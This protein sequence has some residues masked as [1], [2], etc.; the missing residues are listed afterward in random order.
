MK[1]IKSYSI[2][3]TKSIFERGIRMCKN[4]CFNPENEHEFNK[5]NLL[6]ALENKQF[7]NVKQSKYGKDFVYSACFLF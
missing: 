2:D 1:Q 7:F 4:N 5:R 3:S 6:C